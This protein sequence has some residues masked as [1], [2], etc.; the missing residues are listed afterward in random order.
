MHFCLMHLLPDSPKIDFPKPEEFQEAYPGLIA[1]GGNLKAENV[2]AAYR[3]G[4][5]PWYNPDEP[6]MWWSPDPRMV[7]YPPEIRKQKDVLRLLKRHKSEFK[8]NHRFKEVMQHCATIERH[9][10][11]GTWISEDIISAY[12]DLHQRGIAHSVTWEQNGEL[13]A[14]LYGLKL[15]K[16][17]FGESM[18]TR[19]SNGSKACLIFLCEHFGEDIQ[20][21]DCQQETSHLKFMGAK[22]IAREQFFTELKALL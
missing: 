18:F 9:D 17:F 20:L 6:I 4:L 7:L 3:S 10:Q 8:Y 13:L 12:H 15:G 19:V 16:I 22:S 2:V 1:V 5:F 11:D 21:I 14:G